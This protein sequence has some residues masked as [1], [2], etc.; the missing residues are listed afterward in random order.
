M[1]VV[2]TND[3]LVKLIDTKIQLNMKIDKDELYWEQWARANWFEV[4]DKNFK[5]FHNC[6][7][8]RKKRNLISSLKDDTGLLTFDKGEM[9]VIARRYFQNLFSSQE[10]GDLSHILSRID[11]CI[12]DEVN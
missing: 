3:H 7:S 4:G 5:F 2:A 12:S 9:E 10:V 8:C 1:Q 11:C 6:V